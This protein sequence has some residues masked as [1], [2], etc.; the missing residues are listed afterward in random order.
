RSVQSAAR[1]P[2]HRRPGGGTR[3]I[4]WRRRARRAARAGRSP[5]A[6]ASRERRARRALLGPAELPEAPGA[7]RRADRGRRAC[8]PRRVR[9]CVDRVFVEPDVREAGHLRA[10]R[11]SAPDER[12]TAAGGTGF[13]PLF[14]RGSRELHARLYRGA[15]AAAAER[16]AGVSVPALRSCA[17]P[18]HRGRARIVLL[19]YIEF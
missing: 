3:S 15:G 17:S 11:R 8:P 13:A 9:T 18:A 4:R 10:G 2:R 1:P 7:L 19:L 14:S 12:L 16:Y 5:A 6:A